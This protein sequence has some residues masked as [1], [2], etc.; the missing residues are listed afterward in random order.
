M[1][2]FI[3]LFDVFSIIC[4]HSFLPSGSLLAA[5]GPLVFFFFLP[6]LVGI[7]GSYFF[8]LSFCWHKLTEN[9][10]SKKSIQFFFLNKGSGADLACV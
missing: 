5:S 2:L 10:K 1:L 7:G 8:F 9:K 4:L 6:T 3:S